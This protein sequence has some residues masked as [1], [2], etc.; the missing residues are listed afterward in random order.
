MIRGS[1]FSVPVNGADTGRI[2]AEE[3]HLLPIKNNDK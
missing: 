2:Q 1:V 3:V